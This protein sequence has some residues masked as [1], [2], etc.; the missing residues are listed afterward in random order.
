MP[1]CEFQTLREST[2]TSVMLAAVR[3]RKSG[4]RSQ[5]AQ[6]MLCAIASL[7]SVLKCLDINTGL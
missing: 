4:T 1:K 3:V 7:C 5:D 6:Y 2:E